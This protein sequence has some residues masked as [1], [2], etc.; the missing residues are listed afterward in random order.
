[1][2][3][4][5]LLEGFRA[6]GLVT[7][8]LPAAIQK[9]GAENFITVSVKNGFQI[10]DTSRL[11]LLIVSS[12]RTPQSI[13]S[14]ASHGDLTFA[15]VGNNIHVY[16]RGKEQ[17]VLTAHNGKVRMLF[18]FGSLLLSYSADGEVIAW[19]LDTLEVER[20]IPLQEAGA[21][22]GGGKAAV[23]TC[24]MHPSTYLNKMVLGD[25]EGG[26]H[27]LNVRSGKCVHSFG[28]LGSEVTA[29]DQSPA[30]DVV[31]VGLSDGR[32]IVRNIKF[33][34]TIMTFRHTDG[35]VTGLSFRTDNTNMLA[36]TSS[37][38]GLHVWNLES[39]QLAASLPQAHTAAVCTCRF[40]Q[41][42][43]LLIT[44]GA[45]NAVKMW[46]FDQDDGSARLLR[47]RCG[48]SAPPTRV[49]Y[50]SQHHILSAGLDRAF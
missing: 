13:T 7:Y 27:I 9:R 8:P 26:L 38:G 31:G 42:E 21:V 17:T 28:A 2:Q 48:H 14:L 40:L 20:R 37:G 49:K 33:D 5:R 45:D 4:S 18:V 15:A 46:I 19:A 32:V 50:Y 6:V 10:F 44:T 24:W 23:V 30:V 16:R 35:S 25:A 11:R 34:E 12:P 41:G 22:S 39:E 36:S 29:L 1:M 3:R 43:P 47:F